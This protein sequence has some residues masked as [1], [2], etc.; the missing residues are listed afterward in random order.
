MLN[1]RRGADGV[2]VEVITERDLTLSPPRDDLLSR[3]NQFGSTFGT[4][5]SAAVVAIRSPILHGKSLITA[6]D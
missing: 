3:V 4:V 1:L 5:D 6:L 2:V